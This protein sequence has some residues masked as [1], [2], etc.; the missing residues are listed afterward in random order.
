MKKYR[1]IPMVFALTL[2]GASVSLAQSPVQQ[3]KQEAHK[4]HEG[5]GHAMKEGRRGPQS[6]LL[7][8]ITLTDAQKD[9]L[10]QMRS[11]QR[12]QFKSQVQKGEKREKGQ[13]TQ[14]DTAE[15]RKR[16][17]QRFADIR[18]ILTPDQRIV[19]DKNVAEVKEKGFARK[20]GGHKKSR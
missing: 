6:L 13:R 14:R 16:A 12:E 11:K 10:K 20:S 15:F 19:F 3:D 5:R 4:G 1:L 7:K 17:E 18:S 2:G 8:G 9:Q